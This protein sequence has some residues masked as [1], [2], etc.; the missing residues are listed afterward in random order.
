M[1][2]ADAFTDLAVFCLTLIE[3]P[4]ICAALS[5]VTRILRPAGRLLIANLSSPIAVACH[6][7]WA[8]HEDGTGSVHF[9]DY[10]EESIYW[11]EWRGTR[12]Q[13]WHRPTS[14]YMKHLLKA[15]LQLA[16][17]DEPP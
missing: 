11:T 17:F 2:R 5:E 1:P 15:G 6:D 10:L 8:R 4:D 7:G 12:I 16:H 3:F 14:L 13:N 9:R